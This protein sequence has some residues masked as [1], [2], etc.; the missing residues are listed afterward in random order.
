MVRQFVVCVAASAG[1]SPCGGG[2]EGG[3]LVFYGRAIASTL[4]RFVLA[5]ARGAV[6]RDAF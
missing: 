5:E 6:E 4:V 3:S 2:G 1:V